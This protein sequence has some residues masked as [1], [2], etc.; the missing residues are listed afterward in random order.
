MTSGQGATF[1]QSYCTALFALTRRIGLA[2]DGT[3]LVLGASGG[4]GR[5]AV[6]VG[7]ALGARVIAGA[8]SRERLDACADIAPYAFINYGEDDLK[9]K[10]RE[11]SDGGVD[12]VYDPLGGDYAGAGLR[13]LRDD[14]T[15]LIV[16]FAAGAI[17][18]LPANHILLRNRRV[19]GVDWGGWRT[20]HPSLQAELL[21]QLMEMA[22]A[23]QLHPREPTPYP[24]SEA[25]RALADVNERRV[26]GK[27]VLVP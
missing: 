17:P 16:G 8:S 9:A 2:A 13:S 22:E 5:A 12:V 11:L 6:D 15:L 25:T 4:V 23:G 21:V 1:V 3:L 10:A 14:G 26:V 27:V 7:V 18:Q 19:V 24:F 20:R